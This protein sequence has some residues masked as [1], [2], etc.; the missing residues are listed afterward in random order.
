V[1]LAS[2]TYL[3]GAVALPDGDI[4]VVLSGAATALEATDAEPAGVAITVAT[5]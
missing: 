1:K 2:S 5:A 4:V 3:I